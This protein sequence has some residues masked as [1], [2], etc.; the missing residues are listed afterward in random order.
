MLSDRLKELESYGLIERT[1]YPGPPVRVEYALTHKGKQLTPAL[2]ELKRWAR[3]WLVDAA[4]GGSAPFAAA[5]GSRRT[6]PAAQPP[7]ATTTT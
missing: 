2:N 4:G 6:E 1:V 3:Y 7:R 5:G